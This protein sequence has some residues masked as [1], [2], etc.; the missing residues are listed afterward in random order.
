MPKCRGVLLS[1][2]VLDAFVSIRVGCPDVGIAFVAVFSFIHFDKHNMKY[3]S[4]EPRTR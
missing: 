2:G 1:K 4:Y 3:V